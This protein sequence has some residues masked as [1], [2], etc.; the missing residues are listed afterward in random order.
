M[1]DCI[2]CKI[3]RG[4]IPCY[5]VYEDDYVVAFLDNL[6]LSKGHILVLARE[7]Y[8]DILQIPEDT[9][10]KVSKVVRK[11][12]LKLKEEYKPEGIFINQN[13]GIKAGQTIYHFHVHVK[14]IYDGTPVLNETGRRYKCSHEEMV[15][16]SDQ[17]KII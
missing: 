13:N 8:E 12:A 6:P 9:L 15:K 11:V 2:F 3:I 10:C 14:P 16:A 17:L 4:E 1:D 5:K 7:H